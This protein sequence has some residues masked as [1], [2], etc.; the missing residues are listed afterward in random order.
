[1]SF[2]LTYAT[3]F[4]PPADLHTRFDAAMADVR[5]GLGV[6]HGL[7]INGKE[8][9]TTAH[10][11]RRS[12]IDQRCVLG[13]FPLATSEQAKQAMQA[14]REAFPGWRATAP[15]ERVRLLKRVARLIEERLFHISAALTLEVGK[16]RM[17]AMG[18][19]QETADFF[20]IYADDFEKHNAFEHE[21]PNDQIGR[22]HV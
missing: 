8:V 4:N 6:Q 14:A 22:A 18:E 1:M 16:N 13:H 10:D 2:K 7:H 12:P 11:E 5:A 20:D 19:V 15:A 9:A 17:E 21:L 3:M